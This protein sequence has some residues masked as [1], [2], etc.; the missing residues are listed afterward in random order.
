MTKR[1]VA[2]IVSREI[3]SDFG[4]GMTYVRYVGVYKQDVWVPIARHRGI[5]SEV[6]ASIAACVAEKGAS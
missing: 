1:T 2:A 4:D 3:R 6:K 5:Q